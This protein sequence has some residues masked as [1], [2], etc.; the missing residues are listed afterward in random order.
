MKEWN[1]LQMIWYKQNVINWYTKENYLM[2]K[3][4]VMMN[5]NDDELIISHAIIMMFFFINLDWGCAEFFKTITN[6]FHKGS[7][8]S[9]D[10]DS[11]NTHCQSQ[12]CLHCWS[13]Y[14]WDVQAWYVPLKTVEHTT[15]L[16]GL[17]QFWYFLGSSSVESHS[18]RWIQERN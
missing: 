15:K 8:D 16:S 18:F 2:Q 6:I 1:I 17:L 13:C 10:K 3:L 9:V 5:L 14:Y 12:C 4:E 11:P 7:V